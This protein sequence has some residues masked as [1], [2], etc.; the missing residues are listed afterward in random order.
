LPAS[1]V[2]TLTGVT[3]ADIELT[4]QAMDEVAGN[5][6]SDRDGDVAPAAAA[7]PARTAPASSRAAARAAGLRRRTEDIVEGLRVAVIL[8]QRP[9]AEGGLNRAQ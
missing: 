9:E 3:D 2:A 1:R 8:R 5:R 6:G 4:T 7:A